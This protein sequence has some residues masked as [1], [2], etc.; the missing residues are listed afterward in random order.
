MKS[1]QVFESVCKDVLKRQ[2]G[3]ATYSGKHE[4]NSRAST[5]VD[6]QAYKL[7]FEEKLK[8]PNYANVT[9]PIFSN[10]NVCL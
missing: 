2:D 10:N 4:L 1:I 3:K 9:L 5:N 6:L 7:Y 8:V